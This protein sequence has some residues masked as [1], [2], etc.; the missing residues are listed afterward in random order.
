MTGRT[1][2]IYRIV[3]E[4]G[5]GAMGAVYEGIDVMVERQVAIKMLRA[6]IARQPDLIERFRVEAVTLAKLNHPCTAT[7]Y[8]FF[9]EGEDYYMVMEFV[10]GRTLEAIIRE[11]GRLAPSRAVDIL[12]QALEGMAHAHKMGVLHRDIKPANIMI[13]GDGRVKVTDFGIARVLGTARMTREGRIIGTLEYIAPERIRGEE[14]DIRSDLYS[15]GIVLYEALTGRLPFISDTDFGLMQAHLQ[16]APPPL[17]EAG[18]N[19]PADIEAVL[20]KALAKSPADRFATAEEFR[21][22]LALDLAAEPGLKPTRLAEAPPALAETR[23]AAVPAPASTSKKKLPVLWIAAAAALLLV[24]AALIVLVRMRQSGA[25]EQ[26]VTPPTP[27]P[28][29]VQP[30]PEQPAA[31]SLPPELLDPKAA[32]ALPGAGK[33]GTDLSKL[34]SGGSPPDAK[35]KPAANPAREQ[36]RRAAALKAVGEAPPASSVT[37]PSEDARTEPTETV[38]KSSRSPASVASAGP[39]LNSLRDVHK[40]FLEHMDNDL[41]QYLRAEISKQLSSR[42]IV[43]LTREEADAV[44]TGASANKTGTRN[45]I[46]GHYLGLHDNTTGAISITDR[47]GKVVLWSSEAGDRSLL[48][49]MK[50]GGPRKVADRLIHKLKETM[51]GK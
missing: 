22:A 32:I 18:V 6:E 34:L 9:R 37:K 15:A 10:P 28:A 49:G 17:A 23:L 24:V 2:G 51:D 27:P 12:R 3:R 33:G 38:T 48:G 36:E 25:P 11:S 20:R 50:R 31:S 14:A 41:D 44:M 4:L 46:T 21:D 8:N 19:G 43:V 26:A 35:P 30:P 47:A 45:T 7:L 16:Q 13:T 39:T 5:T 40:I 29:V 1:I 42:M